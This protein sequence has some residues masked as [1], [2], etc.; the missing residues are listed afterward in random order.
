MPDEDGTEGGLAS[1]ILAE[2]PSQDS[3]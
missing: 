3:F 2:L 1:L